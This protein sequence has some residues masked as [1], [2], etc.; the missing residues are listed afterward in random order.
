M[1]ESLSTSMSTGAPLNLGGMLLALV[2]LETVLSA[3][4]AIALA[5][6]AQDMPNLQ[7]QRHALNWGLLIAL[8]LRVGL[9]LMASWVIQFW[10]FEM[11]GALYL[12][13]LV[14]K[15]FWERLSCNDGED[16]QLRRSP[17]TL[18]QI[19]PL[20]ALTDLA[21]S[22]DSVTAAVALSDQ[23]GLV[24]T[25]CLIG[26]VMLRVMAGVFI[27]LLATF[28]YLQDAA[29]LTVLGIGLRLLLKACLP[30]YLPPDWTVLMIMGLLFT[31]GFSKRSSPQLL[32]DG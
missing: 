28:T 22:I 32:Q 11:A 6:I 13:G 30:D 5:A 1:I 25:G 26:I 3:D 2:A 14:G 29:Y 27:Q 10:Q 24:L 4:N 9:L 20:I 18:W 16:G 19:I 23:I 12:L 21:F 7:Q 15:H 31:W 17:T 8:L